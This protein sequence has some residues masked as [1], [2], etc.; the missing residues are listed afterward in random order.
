MP[1]SFTAAVFVDTKRS[2]DDTLIED[3]NDAYREDPARSL[4]IK[5]DKRLTWS[6]VHGVLDIIH[7]GGMNTM[8]LA[9]EK[10]EGAQ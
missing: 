8:L 10:D 1:N 2:S 5:G 6:Q 4:L 7:G 9:T 3:I